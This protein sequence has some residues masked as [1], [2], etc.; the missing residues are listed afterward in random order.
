MSEAEL[1]VDGDDGGGSVGAGFG[2]GGGGGAYTCCRGDAGGRGPASV[3][4]GAVGVGGVAA[5][6]GGEGSLP[7]DRVFSRQ[8][9]CFGAECS[10]TRQIPGDGRRWRRQAKSRGMGGFVASILSKYSVKI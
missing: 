4:G 2:G 1:G 6:A 8:A 5:G 3:G 10:R 9:K 7:D